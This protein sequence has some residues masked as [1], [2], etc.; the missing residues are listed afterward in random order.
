MYLYIL[1]LSN[2]KSADDENISIL[3]CSIYKIDVIKNPKETLM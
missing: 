1:I 2:A 3:G